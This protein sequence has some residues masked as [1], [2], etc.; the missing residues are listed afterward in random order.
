VC[1]C[2]FPKG[3]WECG[4]V[5]EYELSMQETL[6]SISLVPGKAGGGVR[7]GFGCGEV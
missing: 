4:F 7:V 1:V 3:A 5:D 2:V 6:G